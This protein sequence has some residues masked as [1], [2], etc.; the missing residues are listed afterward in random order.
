LSLSARAPEYAR[1]KQAPIDLPIAEGSFEAFPNAVRFADGLHAA[2]LRL[3]L[4]S[5]SKNLAAMRG[6]GRAGRHCGSAPGGMALV[7]IARLGDEALL[8]TAQADLVVTSLDQI[9]TAAVPDGILRIRPETETPA[10]A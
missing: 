9:D 10:H 2:G 4:A 7:G 5:S 8:Q 6:R 3:P 1:K